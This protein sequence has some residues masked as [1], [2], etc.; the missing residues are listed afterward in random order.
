M[1]PK[2]SLQASLAKP[3]S[4]TPIHAP[5]P[6]KKSVDFMLKDVSPP[7]SPIP[8]G[9][10]K[11]I[12]GSHSP[13]PQAYNPIPQRFET[14]NPIGEAENKKSQK[15]LNLVM[16]TSEFLKKKDD[17]DLKQNFQKDDLS[18]VDRRLT[19]NLSKQLSTSSNLDRQALLYPTLQ[20]SQMLNG[21][22]EEKGRPDALAAF[23]DDASQNALTS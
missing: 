20:V 22:K 21:E 4:P 17:K 2:I 15:P 7:V 9:G 14:F 13:N 3:V 19:R 16:K 5:R 8:T 10:K 1:M 12:S 11:N 18:N 23:K 6:E